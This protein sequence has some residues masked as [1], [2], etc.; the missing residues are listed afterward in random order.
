MLREGLSGL[1]EKEIRTS[2]FLIL[3]PI[4]RLFSLYSY[5]VGSAAG[6]FAFRIVGAPPN[7]LRGINTLWKLTRSGGLPD[8][9]SFSPSGDPSLQL[10]LGGVILPPTLPNL[11]VAT[12]II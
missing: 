11:P 7:E 5:P 3:G 1:S 4:E 9:I 2:G 12:T 8:I 10:L 6:R